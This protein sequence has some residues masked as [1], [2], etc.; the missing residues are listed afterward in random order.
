[1]VRTQIWKA[2]GLLYGPTALPVL[3]AL[4]GHPES[5]RLWEVHITS[6][7]QSEQFGFQS[8]T[9]DKSIYSTTYQ[10]ERILLLRQVDDFA[11]ACSREEIAKDL[12]AQIGKRLQLPS[13]TMPPFKYLGL[14][15]DF[16]GMDIH[17]Y[18]SIRDGRSAVLGCCEPSVGG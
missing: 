7:L 1:M 18:T 9:Y 13:E 12:Y 17:Q 10:D 4:Q 14:L 16:N 5:G 6:I 8:T 2:A 11:L 15:T 3:H